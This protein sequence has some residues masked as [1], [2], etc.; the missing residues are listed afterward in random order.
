[1]NKVPQG[2]W[3]RGQTSLEEKPERGV[4]KSNVKKGA[5]STL[6]HGHRGWGFREQ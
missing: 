6:A 1:M 3:N 5:C 2:K 4:N